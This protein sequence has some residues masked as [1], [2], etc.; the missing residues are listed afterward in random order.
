[1]PEISKHFFIM[2]YIIA[3][4]LGITQ[5]TLNHIYILKTQDICYKKLQFYNWAFFVHVIIGFIYFYE[6]YFYGLHF[7]NIST[8]WNVEDTIVFLI[9]LSIVIYLYLSVQMM[10]AF[11]KYNIPNG[12]AL[13]IAAGAFYIIAYSFVYNVYCWSHKTVTN[14]G[15]VF[16]M[17]LPIAIFILSEIILPGAV[18]FCC[19]KLLINWANNRKEGERIFLIPVFGIA[20]IAYSFFNTY[21]DICN[22]F[23]V[24]IISV[25]GINIYNLTLLY[26]I[27]LNLA[28]I[29][30]FYN[31]E[32]FLNILLGKDNASSS[33]DDAI[34]DVLPSTITESALK[35]NLSPREIEVLNQICRG[36][37][38]PDI[39]CIL[40]ISNNTVKHHVNSIFKK[41]G[42]KN[43]YELLSIFKNHS[44]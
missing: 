27:V 26:Y 13:L 44:L 40:F 37:S 2:F 36:K 32:A 30:L 33:A 31:R 20:T 18:V 11:S 19:A 38:N 6:I 28:S 34:V 21:V 43:R 4:L 29:P 23:E 3:F 42:V 5:L 15:N 12:K 14:E 1:M 9:N 7:D 10:Q 8:S 25:L 35:Y 17:K 16:P 39:S 24:G 41:T 22:C